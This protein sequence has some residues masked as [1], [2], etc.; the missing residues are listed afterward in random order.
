MQKSHKRWSSKHRSSTSKNSWQRCSR[1]TIVLRRGAGM[2]RRV[3]V[4]LARAIRDQEIAARATAVP[5]IVGRVNADQSRAG[6]KTVDQV[7]E[8]LAIVDRRR[9]GPRSAGRRSVGLASEDQVSAV[10]ATDQR[11]VGR[12]HA[13]SVVEV[14]AADSA[15]LFRPV[16]QW[17]AHRLPVRSRIRSTS[18]STGWS[19]SWTRCSTNCAS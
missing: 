10:R 17:A 14:S 8:V 15:D 7:Q 18:G 1:E 6:P 13:A 4:D 9:E 5:G 2:G 16:D 3:I 19:T 12:N 11:V